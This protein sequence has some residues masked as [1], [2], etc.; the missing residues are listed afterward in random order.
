MK[1]AV[2]TSYIAMA[3][4]WLL[5]SMDPIF[6]RLV[7]DDVARP[8][9]TGVSLAMTGFTLI[10]SAIKGYAFIAKRK[11]LWC[12]FGFYV[13]FSTILADL[14]LVMAIRNLN[15]GL[16]ALTLRS[17]VVMAI[18][19]AWFMFGEKPNLSTT[20]GIIIVVLGYCGTAYLTKPDTRT[21]IERN[22]ALGW[23]CA[24]V[25]S[26]LWTS[27][28]I[29]GKKLMENIKSTQLCGMRMLSAGLITCIAYICFGGG[30]DFLALSGRQW[31]FIMLKSI[32]C[33]TLAYVL[34]MYALHN[35][36]VTA[37]AAMEQAAP[38]YTLCV[39][40]FLLHETIVPAQCITVA[41][42]FIGSAIILIGQY[43]KAK[44]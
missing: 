30:N 44:S 40:Y 13:I 9:M 24:V 12:T 35:S 8:V 34:Y 38:L 16:V 15:P 22:T 5:W 3:F 39:A 1:K 43:R 26:V 7:G 36:S 14:C 32:P 10:F 19:A 31:F 37:S 33:S 17:Q 6:I 20:I 27:G 25:S 21:D 42:V 11:D 41:I 18:L 28:T 23:T 4:A 2:T 29:L